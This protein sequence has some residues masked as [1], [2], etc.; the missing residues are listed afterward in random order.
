[1]NTAESFSYSD[2][3]SLLYKKGDKGFIAVFRRGFK[4]SVYTRCFKESN[5]D[6][7]IKDYFDK[8]YDSDLYCTL[9]TFYKPERTM[10]SL[11]YL[12]ALY[13][14]IDYYKFNLRKD[15]VL[16]FLENDYF[17][18]SIPT[19]SL[20]V[21]S[22]RGLYLIWLIERVPSK[23]FTLWKAMQDYLY[24]QLKDFG[25]DRGALDAA[26]VL[27]VIGSYNTKSN[28]NVSVIEYNDVRYS[29]KYLKEEYLPNVEKKNKEK[30]EWKGKRVF[31]YNE[32]SLYK[33]RLN[34][35]HKLVE[36]RDFDVEGKR[37]IILF[38]Y[39]Y[40]ATLCEGEE[41]AERLTEE[42]NSK[43][44]KPLSANELRSTRSNYIGKYNYKNSTLVDLLEIEKYEM[45][46]M[47]TIIS[48]EEKYDKNNQKRR[49]KR[50]NSEGLTKREQQKREKQINVLKGILNNETN[51]EI[52][53]KLNI[54]LR[55]V[56]VYKK[57]INED[58]ELK[59]KLVEIIE[60]EA[61]S[62]KVND[63]ISEEYNYVENNMDS[64]LS[65]N[66]NDEGDFYLESNLLNS[67]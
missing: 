27:R 29:L 33:A 40:Y 17:N 47:T 63:S 57:E 22:G 26:R 25:A 28:S 43:F 2:F 11:R 58:V 12:N 59:K 3:D 49:A 61:I 23:A 44:I 66:S 31:L 30:R 38:L 7:G 6:Q 67:G 35:L 39:R 19:P 37:E 5:I 41:E 64:L 54:S 34:D 9:N 4:G 50:R 16:F 8:N 60:K 21:D 56:Q 62:E 55:M 36:L 18:Q 14:D 65:N 42:L 45:K 10:D 20:I 46:D 52:A 51:K 32:F 53:D 13:V 15:S 48:K 1:M 24:N